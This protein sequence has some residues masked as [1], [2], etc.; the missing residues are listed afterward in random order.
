M[1]TVR[2]TGKE[3]HE[4]I[5]SMT[6][7]VHFSLLRTQDEV[8]APLGLTAGQWMP[9]VLVSAGMASTP[10]ELAS[11]SDIDAGSMTR[12]LDRLESKSLVC[13]VRSI[14][15]RRVV[16]ITLTVKGVAVAHRVPH[17]VGRVL[18]KHLQGFSQDESTL[19]CRYLTRMIVNGRDDRQLTNR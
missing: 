8:L 16:N 11:L 9:L 12:T 18:S 14:E 3:E 1:T 7:Q 15:D 2:N 4:D 13:R 10:A 6:R 19:L 17:A 5:L